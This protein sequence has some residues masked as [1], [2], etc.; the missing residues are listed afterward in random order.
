MI[1]AA[2][3]LLSSRRP[4]RNAFDVLTVLVGRDLKVLYKRSSLGF[5]WALVSPLLQVCIFVLVFG[6]V[7]GVPVENYASFVF[8]GVIAWGWFHASVHQSTTLITQNRALLRQPGFPLSLLP[9]VTVAVRLFHFCLAL[10]FL[11]ALLWFQGIRPSPSW[12]CLP[13]L[14]LI[15]FALTAAFAYPLAALNVRLRDTQHIVAVLLQL[16]MYLTPVFY[17]LRSLPEGVGGWLHLN[18]IATLLEFWRDVLMH[19]LWPD[20][21]QL[22]ALAAFSGILL[23][24]G[25]RFFVLQ[26]RRFAED[27]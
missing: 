1:T 20:V 8:I 10:P 22:S 4:L 21:A 11:V 13:L 6:R 7:L 16:T 23:V 2:P 3:A 25:Q 9:L 26:S 19:G 12:I 14:V 18:P 5:G 24:G 15:Q 17:S 27:L